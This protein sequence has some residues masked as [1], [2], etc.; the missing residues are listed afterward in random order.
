MAKSANQAP[1]ADAAAGAAPQSKS[2]WLWF[3]TL[4]LACAFVAS[5]LVGHE[6]W[7]E[8][9]AQSLAAVKS[10]VDSGNYLAPSVD[11]EP[12]LQTPPLY[13]MTGA[14][15]AQALGDYL[16]ADQ[17][18]RVASGVFLAVALLFTWL[19][20]RATWRHG[21]DPPMLGAGAA[22]VL[23]L[24][25]S[26]G[27]VWY[28]HDMVPE[29]ALMAGMAMGLYGM[30]LWPRR[31]FWGGL[32]LGT[33][34]G[35]AFMATGF[36]GP[37]VLGVT[38]LILPFL[39]IARFGRYLKGIIVAVIF[40]LPWLLV[41]PLLLRQQDPALYEAW[42]AADTLDRYLAGIDFSNPSVQLQW[43][44]LFLTMAFP[45]WLLT[46]LTLV[47]RPGALFGFP[48]FRAAL[49]VAV[50][51]WGLL[52]LSDALSPVYALGLLVPLAVIGAGG[53]Q[54]VPRWLVWPAH[55]LSALLFGVV[56]AALWGAWVWL[57]YQGEPPPVT[58]L[59]DYLPTDQGFTWQPVVYVTAALLTVIWLWAVMRFRPSRPA[60]LLAWPV[61]VVMVWSLLALHQPWLD[62]AIAEGKLAKAV[63][64]ELVPEPAAAPAAEGGADAAGPS[65]TTATA[66]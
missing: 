33:G 2:S 6:P 41:W 24:L 48:G 62:A 61:G 53:V 42:R 44:W 56:A 34:L 18:A 19:F 5:G 54:R 55:W 22:S 17:A 4:L 10:I 23:V 40:A 58:G 49:I 46:V 65:S 60:A 12:L 66:L 50:L 20:G 52:V 30:A 7:T 39:G 13:Y 28:G 25:S 47:L 57:L 45:A 51:G 3:L 14:A 27:V 11:G 29:T 36:F 15:L 38:A 16:P 63:P 35:I 1:A 64:E 43:L 9:E 59:G 32:W 21:D 8:R 31:V 26:L 37:V